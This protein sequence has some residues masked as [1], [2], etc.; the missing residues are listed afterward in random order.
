MA[1]INLKDGFFHVPVLPSHQALMSFQWEGKTY[2]FQVLPFG[3]SALPW[4]FTHFVQAMV[5]HLCRQGMWVMAYMDDFIIIGHSH[6]QALEHTTCTLSILNQLGWQVNFE[7]SNLMPSQSKEFLGLLIDTTSTPSFKVPPRKSHVLWH[8]IDH[9]LH[10]FRQQGQVPVQKLA[11]VIGQGVA[12]TKAILPA[13]LLL[14]NAYHNTA[15]RANWN[16]LVPLSAATILDL[17]DWHHGLS[18]LNSRL[19]NLRL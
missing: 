18:T 4:L 9:L 16:S 8:N 12:L 6:Q 17:E 5:H 7:K 15:W 10:L 1:T 3:M 13:K 2:V 11:S 19:A 14:C